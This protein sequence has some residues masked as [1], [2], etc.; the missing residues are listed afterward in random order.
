M[1]KKFNK[2]KEIEICEKYQQGK[3]TYELGKE[4]E[5][6]NSTIS[7]ILKRNKIKIR[8]GNFKRKYSCD[9]DWLD[10]LNAEEHFY[11]LGMFFADGCNDKKQNRII[12]ALK[13]S[14]RDILDK[15]K[16]FFQSNRSLQKYKTKE[17]YE[18]G[19]AFVLTS[20]KLCGVLESLGAVERKST[21]LQFPN[22]IKN[23][24]ELKHF[25]RGYF[26]GD[27]G[28]SLY[29]NKNGTY[30]A[31]ITITSSSY[32]C[33]ELK[34]IL[35][36]KLHINVKIDINKTK[37]SSQIRFGAVKDVSIFLNWLYKD[38]RI[39]L[40]RKYMEANVFLNSRNK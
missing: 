31:K 13:E 1:K 30:R 39:Y 32:F 25:I 5:C 2:E 4:Y 12:I 36:E 6:H 21:I 16:E 15:F 34:K 10:N 20:K 18:N 11:F 14:D 3:S 17:K 37:N 29:K 9:E 19:L 33:K 26:D 7:A 8:D 38:S 27:G 28:I 40:K 22:F 23:D 35:E 24:E